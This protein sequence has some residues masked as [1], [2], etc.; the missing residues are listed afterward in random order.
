[1]KCV[2]LVVVVFQAKL[3]LIKI[4]CRYMYTLKRLR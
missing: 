4:K 1:M 2:V 3:G